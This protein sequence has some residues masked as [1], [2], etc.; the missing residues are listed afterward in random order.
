MTVRSESF[1]DETISALFVVQEGAVPSGA[2]TF[3]ADQ[4]K[5]AAAVGKRFADFIAKAQSSV[6]MAIY[7]FRLQ[8]AAAEEV[9]GALN[10]AAKRGVDVR[11]GYFEPPK[12]PTPE[13]FALLG[14]DPGVL[15]D[16]LAG[17]QFDNAVT[18]R[19]I[20]PS[21]DGVGN[22]VPPVESEAITAPHN[23]MHSKYIIRD[24]MTSAAGL[25][26]G[27]A[28]FT[29]DAWAVQDNNILIFEQCQVLSAYYE[30]DFSEMW[31]SREISNSGNFDTA[32]VEVGS[33]PVQ[34]MFAPGRG[35]QIGAEIGELIDTA[36][37]RLLVSS[38]IVSSGPIMGAI[39]DRMHRVKD[40]G[41]IFDGP[42]MHMILSE[43]DRSRHQTSDSATAHRRHA[44]SSAKA[45]QFEQIAAFLHRKDSLSYK[46]ANLHNF[47]HNKFAV[48]D[49]TVVTGSFNFSTNAQRNAENVVVIRSKE[50]A[51]AYAAYVKEL[52][53]TYKHVGLAPEPSHRTPRRHH[54]R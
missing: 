14:G 27:S 5:Q 1:A 4:L 36:Q 42:E 47:M 33:V 38:M 50:I 31:Q 15:D 9:V 48:I 29:T 16:E 46:D 40:F 24:G 43:W 17:A 30:N 45:D 6:H 3:S 34:V 54:E 2:R 49:D 8:N 53:A 35:R 13:A 19:T 20:K 41:G 37:E 10:S 28:N 44:A 32:V 18:V 52:S 12:Q 23:L 11:I 25:L 39:L 22:L 7:D 26:M 51:D 21:T